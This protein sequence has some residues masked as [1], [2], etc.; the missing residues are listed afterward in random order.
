MEEDGG[1][2]AVVDAGRVGDGGV[3]VGAGG[4]GGG[5]DAP[6]N[7]PGKGLTAL[8]PGGLL[9]GIPKPTP[10]AIGDQPGS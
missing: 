5:G 10:P 3:V 9:L 4:G 1:A 8:G 7:P 2:G 6:T